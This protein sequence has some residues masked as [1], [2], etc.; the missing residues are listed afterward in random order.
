MLLHKEQ[1][2]AKTTRGYVEELQ[3]VSRPGH[4]TIVF[5]WFSQNKTP[6]CDWS[7]N[8]Y[9]GHI[10]GQGVSR[11]PK[12]RAALYQHAVQ[13]QQRPFSSVVLAVWHQLGQRSISSVVPAAQ[14]QQRIVN[15]VVSAA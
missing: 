9:T 13:Y 11:A 6:S 1:P 8:E 4:P 3:H 14:C 12:V 10:H 15:S 5:I 7:A 2:V